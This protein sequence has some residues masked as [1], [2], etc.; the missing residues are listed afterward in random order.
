M[1]SARLVVLNRQPSN[2]EGT[3]EVERVLHHG[4]SRNIAVGEVDIHC[5]TNR[6]ELLAEILFYIH[7]RAKCVDAVDRYLEHVLEY[8]KKDYIQ[9]WKKQM[10]MSKSMDDV[11]KEYERM[12]DRDQER[13]KAAWEKK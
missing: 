9:A 8:C 11:E 2:T 10:G 1:G 3:Y 13:R 5:Q 6:S 12:K 4:A 7:E